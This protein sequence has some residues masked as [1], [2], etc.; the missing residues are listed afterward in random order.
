MKY[1]HFTV[2]TTQNFHFWEFLC[3]VWRLRLQKMEE[4]YNEKI[5]WTF[6]DDVNKLE[7]DLPVYL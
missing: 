2:E 1:V 7:V 3:K 5:I 4:L 6:E